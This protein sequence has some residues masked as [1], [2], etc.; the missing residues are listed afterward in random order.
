M[1]TSIMKNI[2]MTIFAGIMFSACSQVD[3]ANP[4]QN[5]VLNSVA[6][7]KET[8]NDGYMQQALDKWLKEE[9]SP[10]VE[11]TTPPSGETA[12]KIIENKDGT[13]KL[14][15]AKSGIVLKEMSEKELKRQK[16]VQAKYNDEGRNFTLQE[17]VDK[18]AV[19]NSMHT[20]DEENSHVKKINAM[21]VIGTAKR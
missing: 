14:V 7:K 11:G 10:M 18:I 15:E 16:E 9:W 20:S 12:V 3:G 4:S 8:K 19:Y 13:A 1:Y 6:G 17:Y 5:S 2:I 21:P